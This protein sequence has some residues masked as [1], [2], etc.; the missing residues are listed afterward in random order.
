MADSRSCGGK[1]D[2]TVIDQIGRKISVPAP[3][4]RVISL[5]PSLT[6]L[7]I[8]LGV[9]VIGR[10]KFCIHPAAVV[11]DIPI[12]GGTKEVNFARIHALNPDLIIGNKEENT[13]EI[14]ATLEPHFAVYLTDVRTV[15]DALTMISEI[16]IV[17]GK[18]A[19][20]QA[21]R[22]E[23][24]AGFATIPHATPPHRVA[25]FIWRNPWMVVGGDT[26]IN[27]MLTLAGFENVFAARTESRYPMVTV[28]EIAAAQPDTLLFST[29]PYPFEQV[30]FRRELEERFPAMQSLVVDGELFSWYGSR[31]KLSADYVRQLSQNVRN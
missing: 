10:T 25:Y 13:Q 6:E 2:K 3:P 1:V 12:I 9:A 24:V 19:E 11:A 29:E 30:R 8:D 18:Q 28:E 31:L 16:G 21:L 4:Q 22:A 26:F 14:V 15:S 20:A 23:I 7:L 5:V 17:V 27:D